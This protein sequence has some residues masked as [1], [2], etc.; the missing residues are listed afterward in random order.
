MFPGDW[1]P[2]LK[3]MAHTYPCRSSLLILGLD[4]HLNAEVLKRTVRHLT[5]QGF[6]A[7]DAAN[8]EG[9]MLSLTEAGMAV[10]CDRATT[11]AAASV[12]EGIHVACLQEMKRCREDRRRDKQ[13]LQQ[14]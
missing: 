7:L 8:K 14:P 6:I 5:A 2:I 4:T 10:A 9:K 3:S 11:G 1:G 12:V 13:V